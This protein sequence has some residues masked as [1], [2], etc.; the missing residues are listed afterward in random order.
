MRLDQSQLQI[1]QRMLE[2]RILDL[3]DALGLDLIKNGKMFVGVCPCHQGD[4]KSSFNLY[5]GLSGDTT[6]VN[7]KC[8]TRHCE[9]CFNINLIGLVRG[10]LSRQRYRWE[11][12]GDQSL[13]FA[14][15][16]K[17]IF[18]F[19]EI[20]PQDIKIDVLEEKKRK[21]VND[22][23]T[24]TANTGKSEAIGVTRDK[25][26]SKLII[27][28]PYFIKRGFSPEILDKYDVGEPIAAAG[29]EMS[30]RSVIPVYD[31][32]GTA[33]IGCAGRALIPECPRCGCHHT[34]NC[35]KPENKYFYSKWRNSRSLKV[36]ANL[37]NY[38]NAKS[39][40]KKCGSCILVESPGNV[41]RL[42][43]AGI[44]I[45]LATFGSSLTEQQ[46]ILLESTPGLMR[47]LLLRDADLAGAEG[48]EKTKGLL[49]RSFN[50]VELPLFYQDDI[51]EM[52]VAEVQEKY[53]P[54]LSKYL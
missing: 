46:K 49:R 30:G 12:E 51:A 28:S 47:V 22:W 31:Q 35:P 4:N 3:I 32:N 38:W 40:I 44:H 11:R 1:L 2:T 25:I 45:G 42:E 37:F 53:M 24:T 10:V 52:T 6:L 7:W 20:R 14:D 19:L 8:R 29:K 39:F 43:E 18:K 26:R 27:P 34:G 23:L 48:M 17:W 50:L 21:F 54:I 36:E 16:L 13:S 33:F 15:T 5:H 41:L 9:K